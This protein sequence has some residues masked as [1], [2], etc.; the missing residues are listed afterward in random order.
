M[1]CLRK[2]WTLTLLALA[3][4]LLRGGTGRPDDGLLSFILLFGFLILLLGLL[5]LGDY[6]KRK[7]RELLKDIF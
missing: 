2:I 1:A 6:L 4:L 3:C 7:I 5:Q